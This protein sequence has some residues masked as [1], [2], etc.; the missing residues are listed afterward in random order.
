M[1]YSDLLLSHFEFPQHTGLLDNPSHEAWIK[2]GESTFIRIQVKLER[3]IVLAMR[4][5]V[6]AHPVTVASLSL[7][8][9]LIQGN[10]VTDVLNMN[11]SLLIE[12][13]QLDSS[14]FIYALNALESLKV[15]LS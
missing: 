14:Q 7:L 1:N 11:E 2:F 5:Y 15:V 8:S 12:Q 10:T 9:D 3:N 13:L 4:Y 6:Q